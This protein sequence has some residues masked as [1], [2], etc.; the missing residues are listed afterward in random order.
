MLQQIRFKQWAQELK[1]MKATGL[2]SEQQA[3]SYHGLGFVADVYLP[4][5]L[6]EFA[7]L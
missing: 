1:L 2:K 4:N 5:V 6:K 3:I 7:F